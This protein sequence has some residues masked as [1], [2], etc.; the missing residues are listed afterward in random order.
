M[1]G[2]SSVSSATGQPVRGGLCVARAL[3]CPSGLAWSLRLI[4]L[5][6]YCLFGRP[7]CAACVYCRLSL[8]L[9]AALWSRSD[10]GH[11]VHRAW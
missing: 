11:E 3:P 9:S 7:V 8:L 10:A 4:V 1:H 5:P 6:V 2:D